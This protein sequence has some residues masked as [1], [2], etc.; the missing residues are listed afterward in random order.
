MMNARKIGGYCL[1]PL[2]LPKGDQ[3]WD[4]ISDKGGVVNGKWNI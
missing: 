1:S 4:S 3:R 2:R